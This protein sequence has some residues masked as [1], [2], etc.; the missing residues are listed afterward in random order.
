MATPVQP[1]WAEHAGTLV[2]LAGS[3][4]VALAGALLATVVWSL[5]KREESLGQRITD[6]F[7]A[8][9]DKISLIVTRLDQ[10]LDTTWAELSCQK[11]TLDDHRDRLE[12]IEIV[13]AGQHGHKREG[14]T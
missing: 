9:G 6:G 3:T 11:A 14:D 13:C 8:L 4:I 2:V 5:K 12:K 1:D 10:R 7:N